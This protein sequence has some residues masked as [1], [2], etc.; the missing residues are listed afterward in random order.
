M[1]Q[2]IIALEAAHDPLTLQGKNILLTPSLKATTKA[3]LAKVKNHYDFIK[4]IDLNLSV[5]KN[6]RINQAH[7]AE[8]TLHV[9]G[10]TMKLQASSQDLY[11]SLDLLSDKI[12][13]A[14]NKHKTKS[15][16]RAKAAKKGASHKAETSLKHYGMAEALKEEAQLKQKPLSL[17]DLAFDYNPE[18]LAATEAA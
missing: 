7:R 6:P 13:T 5:E 9:P 10:A 15:L 17:S 11:A 16:K 4:R 1:S 14:L 2:A 12:L 18:G 8:A 3:L